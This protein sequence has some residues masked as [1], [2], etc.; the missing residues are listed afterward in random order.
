MRQQCDV[1]S[2]LAKTGERVFNHSPQLAPGNLARLYGSPALTDLD[3]VDT[4]PAYDGPNPSSCFVFRVDKQPPRRP[5]RDRKTLN[6]RIFQALHR[7]HPPASHRR[8]WPHT[9][10]RMTSLPSLSLQRYARFSDETLRTFMS[11]RELTRI[12]YF[13]SGTVDASG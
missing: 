1:I 5:R 9:T 11:A 7:H 6:L 3:M 8:P 4:I 10:P 12:F 13:A 2:C